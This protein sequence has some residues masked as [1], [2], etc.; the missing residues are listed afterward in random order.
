M[1]IP[2][3]LVEAR[4]NEFGDW[5][6]SILLMDPQEIQ[7]HKA[8]RTLGEE[9]PELEDFLDEVDSDDVEGSGRP[10]KW[11]LWG[12]GWAIPRYRLAP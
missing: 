1:D 4:E 3:E 7:L 12:G 11:V 10:A 8:L 9:S 2:K 5:P 6:N